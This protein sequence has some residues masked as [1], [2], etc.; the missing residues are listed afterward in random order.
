MRLNPVE[1]TDLTDVVRVR[2]HKTVATQ[3]TDFAGGVGVSGRMLDG[4][5]RPAPHNSRKT[6]HFFVTD[7]E[8]KINFLI[9][10]RADLGVSEDSPR[11]ATEV[12]LRAVGSKRHGDKYIR[13]V[14]FEFR[15]TA[16]VFVITWRF[17]ITDVLRPIISTDFLAHYDLFLD[18]KNS[19]LVDQVTNLTAPG[20]C[21]MPVKTIAETTSC[22][23]NTRIL[24]SQRGTAERRST[25]RGITLKRR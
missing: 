16:S 13:N 8:T 25:L 11:T 9:D 4:A 1:I 5:K 21:N 20:R 18:L 3:Q 6:C 10:T 22:W 7:A 2:I 15:T 12:D 23:H 24:R 17:V 14:E 19:R